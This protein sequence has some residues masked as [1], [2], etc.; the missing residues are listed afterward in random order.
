MH[1]LLVKS[2]KL[3]TYLM[4]RELEFYN[5]KIRDDNFY[6]SFNTILSNPLIKSFYYYL[7]KEKY[8]SC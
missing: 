7:Q 3:L 5:E 1:T 6:L 2:L 4:R 8:L